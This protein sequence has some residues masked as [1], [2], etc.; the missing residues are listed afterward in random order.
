MDDSLEWGLPVR[1]LGLGSYHVVGWRL[2][3]DSPTGHADKTPDLVAEVTFK[4]IT[5]IIKFWG[6]LINRSETNTWI[7]KS[8]WNWGKSP[9]V[10]DLIPWKHT[11]KDPRR[12]CELASRMA[13]RSIKK[14]MVHTERS[15]NGRITVVESRGRGQKAM[16]M[17]MQQWRY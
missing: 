15:R 6:C 7:W 17:I 16:G 3:P 10:E 11:D 5:H 8:L 12:E 4:W 2:S 14:V 1:R 9:K 13:P